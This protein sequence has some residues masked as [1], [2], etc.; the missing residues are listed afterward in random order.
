[1]KAVQFGWHEHY[2]DPIF[3]PCART[4][5]MQSA[6]TI[7]TLET[8]RADSSVPHRSSDQDFSSDAVRLL[9][10]ARHCVGIVIGL[11]SL[12]ARGDVECKMA[13]PEANVI[14]MAALAPGRACRGPG[15][16]FNLETIGLDHWVFLLQFER[17]MEHKNT[18]SSR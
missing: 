2:C 6:Q 11:C 5:A 12:S 14:S 9:G 17:L 8:S 15:M 18:A 1:M 16:A 4:K 10:T 13:Q 7:V 3:A